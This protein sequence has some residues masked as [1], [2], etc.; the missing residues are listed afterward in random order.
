[1]RAKPDAAS[2]LRLSDR[3]A[4]SRREHDRALEIEEELLGQGPGD[5]EGVQAKA[6][7]LYNLGILMR[8]TGR[9]GD[10]IRLFEEV[11]DRRGAKLGRDHPDTLITRESLALADEAAG[12]P[13]RA[14]AGLREVLADCSDLRSSP[15]HRRKLHSIPREDTLRQ[16]GRARWAPIVHLVD[17]TPTRT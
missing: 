17:S 13:D 12:Q 4:E 9:L 8:Q 3:M 14:E 16:A 7:T 6:R 1:M 5:P 10:A 2:V 11:R 15:P